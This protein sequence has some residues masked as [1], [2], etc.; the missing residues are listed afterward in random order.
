MKDTYIITRT[1]AIL[2]LIGESLLQ[3][4]LRAKLIRMSALLLAAVFGTRRKASIA[5]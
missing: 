2:S 5:P 1:K 3:L 4:L